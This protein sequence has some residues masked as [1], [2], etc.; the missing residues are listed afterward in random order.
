MKTLQIT[1]GKPLIGEIS[2][3]GAKNASMPI[4]I[5]SIISK[6]PCLI[7]NI[8]YVSDI[9][10]LLKILHTAGSHITIDG[11]F[12]ANPSKSITIHSANLSSE[13]TDSKITSLIRTSIL[14]LGPILARNGYVKLARPG[15]CN[16][17]DRKIDLHIMAMKK[18]GATVIET[19]EYIEATTNGKRLK[20]A[21]ITFPSI[22]VGATENAIMASVT[23]EGDTI[24]RNIAIEPEIDD[25]ILFLNKLGAKISKTGERE[26]IIQGVKELGTTEHSIIPDRIE[27]ATYAIAAAMTNGKII[28]HNCSIKTF[29]NI[30]GTLSS[31]GV[32]I[33]SSLTKEH[34]ESVEA[35]R[36]P[37][38]LHPIE[39][40]T[41]PYP[42]FPTDLQPQL[43]TLLCIT[44]GTSVIT[45]N[46][47]ENRLQHALELQKLGANI[48]INGRQAVI[49]GVDSLHDGIVTASDLR[50]G[51]ALALAGFV[52]TSTITIENA[53]YIERGYQMFMQNIERCGG[54]ISIKE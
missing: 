22:S 14:L 44:K 29:D 9:V 48:E 18:L 26:L 52:S 11:T 28:L 32:D 3:S 23:A 51:A 34:T 8:P 25:L 21:E 2:I 30:I 4:I 16:I 20:G 46:I 43:M 1:G 35:S 36:S 10:N 42:Y 13:I 12:N 7:H 50:A 49:R 27:A 17:G 33:K 47:F 38:G 5:A 45:E 41:N 31:V 39:I 54:I 37:T 15:G 53:E 40:Q 24:L 19:E 6:E